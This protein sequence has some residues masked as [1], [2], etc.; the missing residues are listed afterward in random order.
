MSATEPGPGAVTASVAAGPAEETLAPPPHSPAPQPGRLARLGP[1]GFAL[2]VAAA[3]V[4]YLVEALHYARG[5]SASPGPGVF[6]QLVAACLIVSA[7][8]TAVTSLRAPA[9]PLGA[10][11]AGERRR[12]G[13][14]AIVV[15][16]AVFITALQTFGFFVGALA[17]LVIVELGTGVRNPFRIAL[18]AILL[19]LVSQ[20]IFVD[21]LGLKF[22][23]T[24]HVLGGSL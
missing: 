14:L 18:F 4:G 9:R 13:P 22:F 10:P 17:V 24:F 11:G 8:G 7:L 3:S 20:L 5:T 21:A 6:P 16:A 19:A 23:S 2:A 15:A 12:V 1:P